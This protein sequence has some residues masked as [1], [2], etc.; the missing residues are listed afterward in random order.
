MNELERGGPWGLL[1]WKPPSGWPSLAL[2]PKG[3]TPGLLTGHCGSRGLVCVAPW[4]SKDPRMWEAQIY[5]E[6][7][8]LTSIKW[9]LKLEF[10]GEMKGKGGYFDY[11]ALSFLSS[12][13]R[14]LFIP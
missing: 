3:G 4:S 9:K 8:L 12:S 11:N 7:S 5:W 1:F 6:T 13:L 2:P 14:F 10:Q